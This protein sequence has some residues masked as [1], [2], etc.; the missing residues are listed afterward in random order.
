MNKCKEIPLDKIFKSLG[1]PI[2][3]GVI[4]QLIQH[5]DGELSC[6]Q[7]DYCV[8]K[9]TFSHHIK[10]LLESHILCE[11]TEGV[12]KFL[13]LNPNIKKLYPGLIETIKTSL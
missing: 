6:G 4:K 11:R 3:M 9:A 7:F 1:D 12:K 10:I 5:E 8:N 13:F 2:R